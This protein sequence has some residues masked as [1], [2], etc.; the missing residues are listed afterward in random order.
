[1]VSAIAAMDK[2][3]WPQKCCEETT[4]AFAESEEQHVVTSPPLGGASECSTAGLRTLQAQ[5][6]SPDFPEPIAPVSSWL[7]YLLTAA[8]QLR[9]LTGFPFHSPHGETLE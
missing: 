7:S 3:P 1:L 4:Y 6:Y 8:G 2:S 9:T 5:P